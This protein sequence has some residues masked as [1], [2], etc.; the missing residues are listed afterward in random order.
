MINTCLVQSCS[1]QHTEH[2]SVITVGLQPGLAC[3]R[4][5]DIMLF[6]LQETAYFSIY[7]T[8]NCG[9]AFEFQWWTLS[10]TLVV[11]CGVFSKLFLPAQASCMILCGMKGCCWPYI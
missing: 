1:R 4:A 9:Y 7:G 5:T 3:S 10:L 11:F 8:V 2:F 6:V